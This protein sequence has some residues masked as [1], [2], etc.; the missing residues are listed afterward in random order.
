MWWTEA[1]A[2]AE[3]EAEAEAELKAEAE[4]RHWSSISQFSRVERT[5]KPSSISK[6]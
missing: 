2:E 6:K 5:M 4:E 1:E 3:T